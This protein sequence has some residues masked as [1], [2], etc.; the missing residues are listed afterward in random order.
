MTTSRT[1]GA[2]WWVG[3]LAA[4]S[5][6][7]ASCKQIGP[8]SIVADRVAY[9][10]AIATSWKE[11]TLLNIV[12]LRYSDTPFFLDVAQVVGGYQVEKT[13]STEFHW[14]AFP[15]S[16]DDELGPQ[17]GFGG[18]FTDRPTISY[19]PEDGPEFTRNLAVP[20][21]PSLVL[22]LLAAG[23]S[24]ERVLDLTVDS[25]NG[26]RNRCL[27]GGLVRPRDPDF[28]PLLQRLGQAQA[29]GTAA[30]RIESGK[31]KVERAFLT[32]REDADRE[33][34]TQLADIRRILELDPKQAEFPVTYGTQPGQP[35]QLTV[36]TRSVL[37]ILAELSA[38]VTVPMQ[39]LAEGRVAPLEVT[40]EDAATPSLQVFS[41]PDKPRE[42]FAAVCYRGYWFWIDDRD[43][44]SKTVFL[45]LKTFLAM[46]KQAPTQALPFVTIS[47]N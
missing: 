23:Y 42:S 8:R 31:D 32:F 20:L 12:R 14:L 45:Y 9:N 47:A 35:S 11:Q 34:A 40:A 33:S 6:C 16:I 24:A 1:N 30:I 4:C 39:H 25:M 27:V 13:A 3:I 37:A 22:S 36:K 21:S 29:S 38:D 43:P 18:T 15:E 28:L 5:L 26:I 46:A 17:L 19:S 10:D 41:G 7:L 44:R 2:R